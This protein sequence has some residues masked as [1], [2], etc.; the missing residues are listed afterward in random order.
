MK[1]KDKIR[2]IK[3]SRFSPNVKTIKYYID[4]RIKESEIRDNWI[5]Y[6]KNNGDNLFIYNNITCV[7]ILYIDYK[8]K[9]VKISDEEKNQIEELIKQ[10]FEIDI[11]QM[12]IEYYMVF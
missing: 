7:V 8:Y 4:N 1:I 2:K 5:I 3:E 6:Y 9:S 12:Y 11:K 10:E